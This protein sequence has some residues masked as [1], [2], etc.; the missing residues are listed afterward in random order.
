LHDCETW[1]SLGDVASVQGEVKNLA[2]QRTNRF[3]L[4]LQNPRWILFNF[5]HDVDKGWLAIAT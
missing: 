3:G 5:D 1:F 4:V 2:S